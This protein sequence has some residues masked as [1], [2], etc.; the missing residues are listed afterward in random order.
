M[1]LL[2][3]LLIELGRMIE[4][5]VGQWFG[6][7]VAV[8]HAQLGT[9]RLGRLAPGQRSVP[10]VA[11]GAGEAAVRAAGRSGRGGRGVLT[12]HPVVAL[13]SH[14]GATRKGRASSHPGC[15]L[16]L[17]RCQE[18]TPALIEAWEGYKNALPRAAVH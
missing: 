9:H 8:E 6:N 10:L 15:I 3:A 7:D 14:A 18:A 2:R 17:M 5:I 13:R 1:L 16:R 4:H 12:V 11:A